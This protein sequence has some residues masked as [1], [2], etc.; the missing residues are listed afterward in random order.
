MSTITLNTPTATC[1]SCRAH[2]TEVMDDVDGVETAEL[3]LR[4]GRT[5]VE[6]APAVI[7]EAEITRLVVEAGY[8]VEG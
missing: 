1:G 2:I 6:C 3:D 5:T 8:P 4:T 7:D